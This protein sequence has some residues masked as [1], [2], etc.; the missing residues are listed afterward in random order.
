MKTHRNVMPL[1]ML[2]T[3]SLRN[4]RSGTDSGPK[5]GRCDED[6]GGENGGIFSDAW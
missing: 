2:M 6:D 1:D 4:R 5:I 3:R